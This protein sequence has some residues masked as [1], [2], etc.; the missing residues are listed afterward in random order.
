MR[1]PI[2]R[3]PHGRGS[4][5]CAVAATPSGPGSQPTKVAG[6]RWRPDARAG[7]RSRS[8]LSSTPLSRSS[9][10]SPWGSWGRASSCN[11][12]PSRTWR[13]SGGSSCSATRTEREPV[14]RQR[15]RQ[16][17]RAPARHAMAA[18]SS[19]TPSAPTPR[20]RRVVSWPAGPG[21]RRSGMPST[22]RQ[23]S[24]RAGGSSPA[25]EARRVPT[26]SSAWGRRTPRSSGGRSSRHSRGTSPRRRPTLQSTRR[27][28]PRR[29]PRRMRRVLRST[30]RAGGRRRLLRAA[31]PTRRPSVTPNVPWSTQRARPPGRRHGPAARLRIRVRFPNASP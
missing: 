28:L 17:R 8:T 23:S 15:E 3:P 29:R 5:P 7:G 27:G 11:G 22:L 26:V 24:R 21:R 2:R 16:R 6:S 20:A 10:P 18:V 9:S 31:V 30:T 19:R 14:P 1:W 13:A 25:T 4:P 12:R